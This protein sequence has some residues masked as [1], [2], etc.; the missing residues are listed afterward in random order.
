MFGWL[1]KRSISYN[2]TISAL[3]LVMSNVGSDDARAAVVDLYTLG[4]MAEWDETIFVSESN[5]TR[6]KKT[7]EDLIAILN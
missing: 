2:D 6:Y 4:V 7:T 5:A 3:T 1:E